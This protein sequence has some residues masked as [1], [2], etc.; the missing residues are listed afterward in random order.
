[1]R[2]YKGNTLLIELV[3]GILFF[4][5]SQVIILQ[6]FAKAQNINQLSAIT[7]S[8]LAYAQD[9]A[10]TLA[11]SADAQQA[12]L[13]LG[14]AATADGFETANNGQYRITATVNRL[15]QPSGLLTT[16]TLNAYH[17]TQRLFTLPAVSYQGG[18]AP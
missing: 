3:I 13:T 11:V 4:A 18:K 10:E 16:V 6:V 8:A 17:G 14:Y 5:L 15:S 9:T 12:L 7:N 1:M 2:S